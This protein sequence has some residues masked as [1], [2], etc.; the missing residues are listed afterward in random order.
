M[1]RIKTKLVK[2]MTE[3]VMEEHADEF[4]EDYTKNKQKLPEFLEMHS[5]KMKNV[6][7]GYVTK[8]V[9]KRKSEK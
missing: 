1:G 2:R 4:T 9:K 3:K 8:L 7:A 6:I 5:D